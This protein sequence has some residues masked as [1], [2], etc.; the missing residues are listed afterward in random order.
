[1]DG[2]AMKIIGRFVRAAAAIAFGAL[3]A[4]ASAGTVTYFHNDLAGS[5]VVATDSGGN[6]VWRESYRPYG[7]R[8]KNE[9]ASADNS[10][11][12]TSRRQDAETGL[13][14]MGARYYDPVIGRFIS[15]DPKG[16][17]EANLHSHNRYAYANNSP[18]KYVDPDGRASMLVL[19]AGGPVPCAIGTGLTVATAF[20]AA[21]AVEG[22]ARALNA[23]NESASGDSAASGEEFPSK[24]FPDRPLPRDKHGNPIPDPEAK[25][26]PHTQLGQKDGR[27][28]KYDQ[29]REFD[30]KGRPVRDVDFTDHGRPTKHANPHEHP[31]VPNTSGG[32]PTRGPDRPLP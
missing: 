3:S 17:D 24:R 29:A 8:I 27:S 30:E 12:F 22:T 10:V 19:C 18:Y 7:E 32:T 15:E 14:Y 11:W 6:V 4:V 20:Y 13:V 21:R 28:G 26:A 2:G 16:L 5:P 31:Y 23:H 9:P 25:G 1:M